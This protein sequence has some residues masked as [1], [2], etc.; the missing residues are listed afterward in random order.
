MELI[1]K[2][3]S[4]F[5]RAISFSLIGIVNTG[6]DFLVFMICYSCFALAPGVSHTAGYAAGVVCS[7]ILNRSITFKDGARSLFLQV[8]LFIAVNVLSWK[9]TT[10][11]IDFLSDRGLHAYLAKILVTLISMF[12][13]YFGYK[14]LVFK[15]IG[16]G[17]EQH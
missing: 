13:N 16:D 15:V 9:V 10:T 12:I 5:R 6:V 4:R 14:K 8:L 7:F 2:L 1:K 17:K 11:L 3:F